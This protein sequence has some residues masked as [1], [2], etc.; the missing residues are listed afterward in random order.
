[1]QFI[2]NMDSTAAAN[3]I[4]AIS[5][6]AAAIAAIASW[7]A[8]KVSYKGIEA[9]IIVQLRTEF[10]SQSM[11]DA[12][13]QLSEFKRVNRGDYIGKFKELMQQDSDEFHDLNNARRL[14]KGYYLKVYHLNR[15]GIIGVEIV[16]SLISEVQFD[17]M[18][19]T[20]EPFE[21]V[22]SVGEYQDYLFQW[23]SRI[24]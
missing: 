19:K 14:V 16:K 21:K 15:A 17:F 12:L 18:L 5:A 11:H 22:I 3:I 8:V 10:G 6:I 23:A 20:L 24:R 1:M 7:R 13:R 2:V 9:Q 4:S